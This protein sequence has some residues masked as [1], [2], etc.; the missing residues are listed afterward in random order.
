LRTRA[1]V[2]LQPTEN[3]HIV[4][5]DGPAN[6][7]GTA[8][9]AP[10]SF[11]SSKTG[12]VSTT[13]SRAARAVACPIV[14]HSSVRVFKPPGAFRRMLAGAVRCLQTI[15]THSSEACPMLI[16]S[17]CAR[18][19]GPLPYEAPAGHPHSLADCAYGS[20]LGPVRHCNF[21][22]HQ[23]RKRASNMAAIVV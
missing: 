8:L 18:S 9:R 1:L 14:L 20:G 10:G 17:T 13:S 22:A 21:M 7:C 11:G 16:P 19:T 6:L 2:A 12:S 3:A 23:Y 4:S 15:L 5:P